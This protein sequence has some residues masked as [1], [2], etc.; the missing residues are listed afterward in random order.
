MS[1]VRGS[2]FIVIFAS[3]LAGCMNSDAGTVAEEACQE[4]GDSLLYTARFAETY[5]L[6][7]EDAV[8]LSEGLQAVRVYRTEYAHAKG[9]SYLQVQIYIDRELGAA[10][11][12]TEGTLAHYES[13]VRS[14]F[15][16]FSAKPT[17][18]VDP[19]KQHQ[20]FYNRLI[21]H[22]SESGTKTE[23]ISRYKVDLAP[24]ITAIEFGTAFRPPFD[25]YLYRG[26]DPNT[27]SIDP[28]FLALSRD[29]DVA[30]NIGNFSH[31]QVPS[32]LWDKL[33]PGCTTFFGPEV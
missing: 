14:G 21:L 10:L 4:G 23:A 30:A 7:P 13:H 31:M 19:E 12:N 11:R 5:G 27:K 25:L 18:R 33:E 2:V 8:E 15:E 6:P 17:L 9:R 20:E 26:D 32:E 29:E 24:G 1:L 22:S 28:L 16:Y 3:V